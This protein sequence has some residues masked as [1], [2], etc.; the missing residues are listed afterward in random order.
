LAN[1]QIYEQAT[2][3]LKVG[4]IS[5]AAALQ[6][7]QTYLQ[8]RINSLQAYATFLGDTASLYQSLGGGWSPEKAQIYQQ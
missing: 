4:Y 7:Q 1:Q 5:E 6:T 3:Q 8:A 2:Q